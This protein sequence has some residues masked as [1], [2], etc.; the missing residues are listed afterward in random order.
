MK[1]SDDPKVREAEAAAAAYKA[2]RPETYGAQAAARTITQQPE[3]EFTPTIPPYTPA[4][5]AQV[6]PHVEPAYGGDWHATRN[7][8]GRDELDNQ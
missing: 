5:D 8:P 3:P 4:D 7:G 1:W 6:A 2:A